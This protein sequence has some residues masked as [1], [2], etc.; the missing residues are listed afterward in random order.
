[1][2]ADPYKVLGI[3]SGA[4][5]AELKKAYRDMSKKYHPDANPQDPKAA[6]E[7]FK[8]VQEA[9]RQIT[10]ARE[11]GT[12]AYGPQAQS[13][14]RETGPNYGRRA[15]SGYREYEDPFSAFSDFFR[16]WQQSA[17]QGSGAYGRQEQRYEGSAGSASSADNAIRAAINYINAGRYQEA[18]NA[19]QSAPILSRDARWYYVSAIANQNVGNNL[20]AVEHAK[21]AVDMEPDNI[22]YNQLLNRLQNG[23]TWYQTRGS[24]YGPVSVNSGLCFSLCAMNILCGA[25]TGRPC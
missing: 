13:G 5:D 1:M 19:L 14:P 18:I 25:C 22:Q 17:S 9:Y 10:D 20:T 7:R 12:S 8:E 23:G 6:E 2:I 15:S 24:A 11:R 4:T 3:S 16:E 21:R